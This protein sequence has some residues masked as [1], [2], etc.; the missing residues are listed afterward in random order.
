[1]LLLH[2]V[3]SPDF[4]VKSYLF[5]ILFWILLNESTSFSNRKQPEDNDIFL[6]SFFQGFFFLSLSQD[7][8][9]LALGW[10]SVDYHK[11]LFM[12][13]IGNALQKRRN[14]QHW[15]LASDGTGLIETLTQCF[16]WYGQNPL[17]VWLLP[18]NSS[19][20]FENPAPWVCSVISTTRAGSRFRKVLSKKLS[21][22]SHHPLG[23]AVMQI[24]L[25][26]S[27]TFGSATA[28]GRC[29]SHSCL[30]CLLHVGD[31]C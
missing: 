17:K 29:S 14:M 18:Q 31:G 26:L 22:G 9:G 1:M 23:L 11:L 4:T 20:G 12:P 6:T 24:L 16:Y 30:T 21:I 7:L 13:G 3:D 15:I 28:S 19:L 8:S 25:L 5:P 10:S 27:I 2:D